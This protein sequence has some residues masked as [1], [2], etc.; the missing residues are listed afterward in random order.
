M[1]IEAASRLKAA[2]ADAA[3][4]AFEAYLATLKPKVKWDS[5]GYL[6]SG[7]KVLTP[8][9]ALKTLKSYFPGLVKGKK[10]KQSL[11]ELTVDG[12]KVAMYSALGG[13]VFVLKIP[14]S[15]QHLK[16][17][18]RDS[19]QSLCDHLCDY[20]EDQVCDL[21]N[22]EV[23]YYG[24]L[25]DLVASLKGIGYKGEGTKW[26]NGHTSLELVV[27]KGAAAKKTTYIREAK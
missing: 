19:L 9:E 4:S 5:Q 7:G 8:P 1:K 16:A 12:K 11:I 21:E 15:S 26:S 14:K 27:P 6:R 17:A 13:D 10:N 2:D 3:A 20:E 24:S 23:E 22:D 18:L 25:K